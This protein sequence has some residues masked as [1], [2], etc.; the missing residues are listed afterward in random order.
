MH[1]TAR[2]RLVLLLPFL[3]LLPIALP[4]Q[5][6]GVDERFRQAREAA[7]AERYEEARRLC[8]GILDEVPDYH[9]VRILLGRTYAWEGRFG[10]A[11]KHLEEVLVRAPRNR[12]ALLALVNVAY[13]SGNHAEA[14]RAAARALVYHP[15]DPELMDRRIRALTAT[16]RYR[17]A[18]LVYT[19]LQRTS[20]G[21]GELKELRDMVSSHR[22]MNSVRASW[23]YDH[24]SAVF[25]PSQNL[26]LQYRRE[27]GMGP[28]LGRLRM[29]RRFGEN[30]LQGEVD[31][32]PVF[33]EGFYAYLSYAWSGSPL[34]PEHRAGV[35]LYHRLP[36][37]LE[38]S[39]GARHLILVGGEEVTLL[40]GSLAGYFG[41]WYL[42]FKPFVIPGSGALDGSAVLMARRYLGTP[43]SYLWLSGSMGVSPSERTFQQVEAGIFRLQSWGAGAGLRHEL[44]DAVSAE[45]SV[46]Y[47]RQER[48]N[49]PDRYLD[50]L[51]FNVQLGYRF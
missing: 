11:R 47:E 41:S 2:L 20:P 23:S 51:T 42:S 6:A 45:L 19:R 8:L 46:N 7:Y 27:T 4:A 24:Y 22:Y 9:E 25:G 17:E 33:G 37:S 36:L 44:G 40:T 38:L 26:F 32:Y 18:G 10:E 43:D 13:W 50:I 34:Y 29:Q 31:W 48:L 16:Q 35:E 14:A 30:G 28:V 49:A 21:Y 1:Q 3:L 12:D 15:L 5:Q 39:L